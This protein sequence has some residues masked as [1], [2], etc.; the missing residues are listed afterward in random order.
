MMGISADLHLEAGVTGHIR[1]LFEAAAHVTSRSFPMTLANFSP[2]RGPHAVQLE[3]LGWHPLASST[4]HSHRLTRHSSISLFTSTVTPQ[5]SLLLSAAPQPLGR[6]L[7]LDRQGL[8]EIGR[9][10]QATN[11]S[12]IPDSLHPLQRRSRW[13]ALC[14]TRRNATPAPSDWRR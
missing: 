8:L 9:C 1:P 4:L 14:S 13:P 10:Q 5:V 11:S 2:S 7:S 6:S 12:V 3:T